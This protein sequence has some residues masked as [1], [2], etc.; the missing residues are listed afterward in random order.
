MRVKICHMCRI[1]APAV[2][3]LAHGYGGR[4]RAAHGVAWVCS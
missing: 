4:G 3:V 2:A 1:Q